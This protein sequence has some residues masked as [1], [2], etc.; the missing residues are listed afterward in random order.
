MTSLTSLGLN[1][2]EAINALTHPSIA[3]AHTSVAQENLFDASDRTEGGEVIVWWNDL[4]ADTRYV[5][6]SLRPLHQM[7][8]TRSYDS[9]STSL[10]EVGLQFCI[11]CPSHCN[12]PVLSA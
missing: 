5:A 10:S 2:T 9:W 11:S 8:I 1:V 4:E 7:L 6:R 3:K 12:L